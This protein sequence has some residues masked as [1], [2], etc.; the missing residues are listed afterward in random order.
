MCSEV[1]FKWNSASLEPRVFQCTS[2][3]LSFSAYLCDECGA[4]YPSSDRPLPRHTKESNIKTSAA[5][6]SFLL[7]LCSP[8]LF[9]HLSPIPLSLPL[10]LSQA[11][12]LSVSHKDLTSGESPSVQIYTKKETR[13]CRPISPWLK[14]QC[15]SPWY[16]SGAFPS[17]STRPWKTRQGERKTFQLMCAHVQFCVSRAWAG[18][19]TREGNW[20]RQ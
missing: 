5:H 13:L 7:L 20:D 18:S 19:E 12:A 4:F 11:D 6:S 9:P 16:S 15:T 1:N 3:N 17:C 2:I 14:F 8:L 10:S